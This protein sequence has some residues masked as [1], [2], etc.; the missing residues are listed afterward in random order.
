MYSVR[1]ITKWHGNTQALF[2]LYSTTITGCLIG[3]FGIDY[4]VIF[5]A[6]ALLHLILETGLSLSGIRKG[7]VFVFG[8]KLP[9]VADAALRAFVE[10][11]GFCVPAF[12]V[13]DQLMGDQVALGIGLPVLVVSVGSL[14]MGL[15]DRR[16]VRRL[17]PGEEPQM[18]RRAMTRPGAVMLLSLINTGCLTALFLMPDPYRLHGFIYVISYASLAMLYYL[19]NYNLGVRM[20]QLH[21]AKTDEYTTPGPGFQAVALAYDCS[22]EMALLISPAYWVTFYLGY[23]TYTTL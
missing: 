12:F 7:E 16:D 11:P 4:L 6:S 9:R 22:Y 23:F 20:V 1:V 19:F 13:A 15:A 14:F 3:W 2:L 17:P 8:V 18:S 21:D 10:G 5:C